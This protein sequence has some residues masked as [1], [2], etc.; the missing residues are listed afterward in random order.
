MSST[1]TFSQR[2][3][4]S[5]SLSRL[6]HAKKSCSREKLLYFESTFSN[7]NRRNSFTPPTK[8]IPKI[9]EKQNVSQRRHFKFLRLT[10]CSILYSLSLLASFSSASLQAFCADSSSCRTWFFKR[11]ARASLSLPE[12]LLSSSRCCKDFTVAPATAYRSGHSA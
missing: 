4:L 2:S 8:R 9:K 1:K 10:S 7:V 3:F 6:R 5:S 12:R 11:A